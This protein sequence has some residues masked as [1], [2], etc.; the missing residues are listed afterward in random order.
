[1]EADRAFF[2]DVL[3]FPYVDAHGGW[4]IFAMPPVELG[5]HPDEGMFAPAKEERPMAGAIVYLMC[6]NLEV[7]IESMKSKKIK[8]AEPTQANWGIT[9]T[10]KLPSGSEIGLYQPRHN[11]ATGMWKS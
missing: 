8:F 4:L 10:I 1:S 3:E 11:V 6:D 7:T 9:T 2:R 5:I